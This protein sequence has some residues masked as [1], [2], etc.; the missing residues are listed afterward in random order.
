M[1]KP[2]DHET[3]IPIIEEVATVSTREVETDRL[4][5][6]TIVEERATDV[7]AQLAK[8]EL[9]VERRTVER[10]VTEAPQPYKEGDMLIVPIV[11]ERLVVEKKLFVTEELMV[12]RVARTEEV[13]VPATLRSMRAIVEREGDLSHDRRDVHAR[14]E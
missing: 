2:E 9:L 7:V 13:H 3:T 1:A 6:R 4:R 5:V 8:Q 10:E 14:S 11:E 12:R